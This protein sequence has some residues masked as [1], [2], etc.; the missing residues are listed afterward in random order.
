[1][2]KKITMAMSVFA[3]GLFA[4]AEGAGGAGGEG[5]LDTSAVQAMLEGLKGNLSSWV[6]TAVPVLGAI[7][8][9]FLIFW[10]GKVIFRVV[11]G[12]ANKAG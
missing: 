2:I 5:G 6:T 7:A 10:L 4:F 3:T 1:M 9:S 11:K 8:G 12:W